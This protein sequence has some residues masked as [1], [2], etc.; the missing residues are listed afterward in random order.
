[1]RN[2]ITKPHFRTWLAIVG[3]CTLL[4]AA[5][6][7]MA[8]QSTRLAAD[9]LPLATAQTVKNELQTGSNPSDVVSAVKTN[10]K[11]DSTVFVIIVDNTQHV[12]A[13]SATLSGETPLPP[14]GVF[15]YSL[16]HGNDHFTWQPES[17][18][19]LATRVLTYSDDSGTGFVIT[20]QSL[21]QAESRTNVYTWIALGAWIAIV[22]WSTFT[23]LLPI[24]PKN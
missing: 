5:A 2:L 18:V 7:S 4:L 12:L 3:A 6:Y 20:G 15:S 14:S 9:D 24:K 23:L 16:A 1:M 21:S 10:L 13:S 11:T 22:A 17:G 19:R 8:Q